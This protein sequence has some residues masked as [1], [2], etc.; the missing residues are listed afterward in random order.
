MRELPPRGY[1]VE[2][3]TPDRWDKSIVYAAVIWWS[4]D[5]SGSLYWRTDH[6]HWWEKKRDRRWNWTKMSWSVALKIINN[7]GTIGPFTFQELNDRVESDMFGDT[8]YCLSVIG[9][10]QENF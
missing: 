7:P 1:Y 8:K 10:T 5:R 3:P 2:A 9:P 4:G 6:K